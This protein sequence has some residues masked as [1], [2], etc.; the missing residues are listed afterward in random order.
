MYKLSVDYHWYNYPQKV[1]EIIRVFKINGVPYSYDHLVEINQNNPDIISEANKNKGI[2]P[3]DLFNG[4]YYLI[5]EMAHPL[6]FDLEIDSPD[7][8][9]SD[10]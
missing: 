10:Q 4:S 7:L 9:P 5:S 8:L 2:K 3:E 6:L 1:S